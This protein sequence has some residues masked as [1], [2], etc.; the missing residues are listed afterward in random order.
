MIDNVRAAYLVTFL[1]LLESGLC[2]TTSCQGLSLTLSCYVISVPSG[3]TGKLD[4]S[5]LV[6]EDGLQ[7]PVLHQLAKVLPSVVLQD[8]APKT[9]NSYLCAFWGVEVLGRAVLCVSST[10]GASGVLPVFSEVDP[11]EQVSFYH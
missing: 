7:H 11:G 4:L 6:P 8:K 5:I 3:D 2:V 9:V 1:S 10:S